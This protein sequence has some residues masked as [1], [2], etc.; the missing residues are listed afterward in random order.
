[1]KL[2]DVQYSIL[3]GI[4]TPPVSSLQCLY[5]VSPL[6]SRAERTPRAPLS[7]TDIDRGW[8]LDAYKSSLS[9]SD[10]VLDGKHYDIYSGYQCGVFNL[11][12]SAEAVKVWSSRPHRFFLQ[13]ELQRNNY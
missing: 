4:G 6:R 7:F 2:Q 13:A 12:G 10:A 1:V 5:E 9:G 11:L 8:H 3:T